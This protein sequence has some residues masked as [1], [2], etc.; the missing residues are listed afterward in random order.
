VDITDAVKEMSLRNVA[1]VLL[2]PEQFKEYSEHFN[3]FSGVLSRHF[4]PDNTEK[5]LKQFF[6]V[7]TLKAFRIENNYSAISAT[8]LLCSFLEETQKIE[9][10]HLTGVSYR[11]NANVLG[12]DIDTIRNLEIFASSTGDKN[13]GLFKH[14]NYTK[15]A[16]GARMLQERMIQPFSQKEKIIAE[17]QKNLALLEYPDLL[18]EMI[19]SF[20]KVSDIERIIARI[21]T[22]RASISDFVLLQKSIEE[23]DMLTQKID[24]IIEKNKKTAVEDTEDTEEV[25]T[26]EVE[27]GEQ[28]NREQENRNRGEKQID[29]RRQ[30][31]KNL[32][33]WIEWNEYCKKL[34]N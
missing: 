24:F 27:R 31:Q 17:Y 19:Y 22:Q 15:T 8:A 34:I 29:E 14:I 20:K 11:T 6:N 13:N 26:G 33:S 4:L 10:S 16:M 30:T 9:L 21:S 3:Y 2:T 7:Q 1:E 23:I 18:D 25:E 5:F 12:L 28:E 32:E